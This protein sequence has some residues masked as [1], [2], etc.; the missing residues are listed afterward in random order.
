MTPDFVFCHGPFLNGDYQV[1]KSLLSHSKSSMHFCA[2]PRSTRPT[3]NRRLVL[4]VLGIKP[5]RLHLWTTSKRPGES[6]L[7]YILLSGVPAIVLPAAHG[8]PL[9]AWHT[10]TLQQLWKL[11]LPADAAAAVAHGQQLAI[12]GSQNEESAN[13]FEGVLAALAEYVGM[14]VDW[15]RVDLPG[16]S[17]VDEEGQR[18]E[19]NRALAFLLAAAVR[20]G[21]SKKVK[22]KVDPERAG[23]AFWRIV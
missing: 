9:I 18:V 4:F 22:N 19:V 17:A 5:H 3:Q 7:Q 20:S 10:K 23:I 13:T 15:S 6:V 12:K 21:E 1:G 14:C 16:A 2:A 8:A 11:S